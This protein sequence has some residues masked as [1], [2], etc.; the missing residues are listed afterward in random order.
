MYVYKR[1]T[2]CIYK[3]KKPK[4]KKKKKGLQ[5]HNSHYYIIMM[6]AFSTCA[7]S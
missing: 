1:K 4:L 7:A 5:L 6:C 2:V 3:Q